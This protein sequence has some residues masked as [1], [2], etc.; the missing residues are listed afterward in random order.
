MDQN[1]AYAM[2]LQGTFCVIEKT[3]VLS[4]AFSIYFANF[5]F[6]IKYLVK[7]IKCYLFFRV[8]I[9]KFELN[10]VLSFRARNCFVS[11]KDSYFLPLSHI[12]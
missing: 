9:N 11:F 6:Y 8:F 3:D 4:L 1:A 2:A 7:K 10:F 5:L 12:S